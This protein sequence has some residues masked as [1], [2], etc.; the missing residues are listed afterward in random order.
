MKVKDYLSEEAVIL[1]LEASTSE[2]VIRALGG[3]LRELGYV[4]E[5]FVEAALEREMNMPTGLPLGGIYNAAIPH[6]DIEYVN[7]SALGLATLRY[8][9]VFKNMVENQVDVP[10]QLVIMLALDKP[11]S[12]VE[13]LQSVA[14]LLQSPEIIEKIV[15]AQTVAEI[16][17]SLP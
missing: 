8:P 9:V 1:G 10:C 13:M 2:E 11:K 7:K 16:F 14:G 6:V 4:K 15:K 5:N 12:Q 3:R 17:K